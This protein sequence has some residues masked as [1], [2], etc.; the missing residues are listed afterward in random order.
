MP[1]TSE[2]LSVL[3]GV[4]NTIITEDL[5]TEVT[6]LTRTRDAENAYGTSGESWA[7]TTTYLAWVKEIKNTNLDAPNKLQGTVNE[8]EVRLPIHAIVNVGD[9]MAIGGDVYVVNDT[10]NLDSLPIFMKA[11]VRKFV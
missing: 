8:Y 10:N 5:K 2:T 4:A 11:R 3:R 6:V 7:G 9:R 1:I